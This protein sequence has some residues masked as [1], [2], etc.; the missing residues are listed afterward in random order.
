MHK[1]KKRIRHE[2]GRNVNFIAKAT[3]SML[4]R[5]KAENDRR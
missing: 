1:Q 2:R 3:V 5:T 4:I